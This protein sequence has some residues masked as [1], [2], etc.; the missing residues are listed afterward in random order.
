M[1]HYYDKLDRIIREELDQ[2]Q[3]IAIYPL[4]KV[5]LE[6]NYILSSRYGRKGILIDNHMASYNEEVITIDEFHIRDR[7]DIT[8][9]LCAADCGLNSDLI[10]GIRH[11]GVK[12]RVRN[13]LEGKIRYF[14]KVRDLCKAAKAEGHTLVRAGGSGDG[15]YVMLDDFEAG[16]T[17][18]SFGIGEDISWDE[19]MAGRGLAVHCYDHTIECLPKNGSGLKFHRAGISGTDRTHEN[20]FS[21]ETLLRRN[22]DTDKKG[23]IL[24]MDVEGAEWD[25]INSA[26]SDVLRQFSQITL[27]LHGLTD[28][29]KEGKI[30]PALEKLNMTHQAVW[31]HGNNNGGEEKAGGIVMPALLEITYAGRERYVFTPAE[32]QCPLDI[33]E[34]NMAGIP[35]IELRGWGD[36]GKRDV[37]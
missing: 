26:P 27:E 35:D 32:Y 19:W 7:S 28:D 36:P 4:G 24:K 2:G 22:G 5:G 17:A 29:L 6:A 11:M 1:F 37:P 12:A 9:V 25:F 14:E 30:I 8:V 18:Y 16:G 34:P 15:A 23:M 13:L 20:L 21:I 33:D 10:A 31:V 3:T